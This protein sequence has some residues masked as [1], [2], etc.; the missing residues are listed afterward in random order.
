MRHRASVRSGAP[1]AKA[2]PTLDANGRERPAFLNDLPADPELERLAQAFERGDY[3]T[4]RRGARR[5]LEL[6]KNA[7]VREA[8]RELV[9][10]TEPDPLM[11]YLLGI[12]V[13][14]LLFLILY[15]YRNPV[16]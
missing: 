1:T 15:V 13:A 9:E 11:K 10:R 8:A 12:A 7:S 6:S 16:H 4:V 3:A 5:L 2:K 14:L